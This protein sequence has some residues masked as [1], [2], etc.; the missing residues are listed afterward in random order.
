MI[1]N[2]VGLDAFHYL[3]LPAIA[4]DGFLLITKT[5]LELFT[6]Y[7]MFEFIEK[8]IIGIMIYLKSFSS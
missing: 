8:S 1:Q 4:M 2:F 6:Q 5:E 3:S 7:E